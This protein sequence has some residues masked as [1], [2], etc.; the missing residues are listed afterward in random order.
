MERVMSM[1]S[2]RLRGRSRNVVIPLYG[3]TGMDIYTIPR[4]VCVEYKKETL[5]GQ[6]V[7]R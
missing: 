3:I 7:Q 2:G 1:C 5:H 4:S 6:A